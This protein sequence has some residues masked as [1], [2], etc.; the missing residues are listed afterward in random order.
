[1]ENWKLYEAAGGYWLYD[2]VKGPDLLLRPIMISR[3]GADIIDM[4]KSGLSIAEVTVN[5]SRQY[6]IDIESAD[7]DVRDFINAIARAGYNVA[8]D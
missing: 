8:V 5:I 6:E 4:L 2:S 1:M 7:A 3:I